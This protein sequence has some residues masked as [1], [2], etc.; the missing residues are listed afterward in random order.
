[1]IIVGTILFMQSLRAERD[2]AERGEQRAEENAAK[3]RRKS[4]A[5]SYTH[6]TLPTN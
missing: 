6:L 4:E 1:M 5:V 2:R 3:A